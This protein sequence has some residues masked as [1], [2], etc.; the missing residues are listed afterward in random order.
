MG[1]SMWGLFQIQ[2]PRHEDFDH[3]HAGCSGYALGCATTAGMCVSAAALLLL[4]CMLCCFGAAFV[5]SLMVEASVV[6]S[7][8][9][10]GMAPFDCVTCRLS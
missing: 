4:L 9:I 6:K 7:P 5:E 3:L 1:M 10:H 8:L 2:R